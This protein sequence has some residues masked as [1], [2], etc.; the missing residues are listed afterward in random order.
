MRLR[1]G[2]NVVS[3]R[4]WL[5]TLPPATRV[6]E[7]RCQLATIEY[8]VCGTALQAETVVVG[9]RN[10]AERSV[11]WRA[12]WPPCAYR[13]THQYDWLDWAFLPFAL[14][15][16]ILYVLGRCPLP[17]LLFVAVMSL[18]RLG[19][20]VWRRLALRRMRETVRE[21][22]YLICW[23]CGY[24]LRATNE[25]RCPECGEPFSRDELLAKWRRWADGV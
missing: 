2:A 25:A 6:D 5:G 3:Y 13:V 24:D 18:L 17:L 1:S 19:L 7:G 16:S 15:A 4:G 11:I 23:D 14:T 12:W 9:M 22:G 21:A 8:R 10:Q 20:L